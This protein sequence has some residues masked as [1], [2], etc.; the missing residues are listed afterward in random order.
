MVLKLTDKNR[1]PMMFRENQNGAVLTKG[2]REVYLIYKSVNQGRMARALV[3]KN[4]FNQV[5]SKGK[6]IRALGDNVSYI[7]F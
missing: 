2:K 1:E 6:K 3:A 4:S 7:R 5:F